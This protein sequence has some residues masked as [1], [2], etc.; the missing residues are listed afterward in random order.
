MSHC[1]EIIAVGTE[2]LL[3]NIVNSDAQTVAQALSELGIN[4]YY[5]T[6]VGDNPERL[7][8]AVEIARSRAD[9]IITTGGLGPTFDDLTKQTLA[10]AFGKKLVLHEEELLKI[11]R[12]FEKIGRK[13]TA[14]NEQ[15]AW[16]PEGCT[17]L[18]NDWGTAPGCAFEADG[19]HVIMLPGPPRECAPMMR[20][21]A[22]P[23]LRALSD[24]TLVSH[25][26]HIFGMGEGAVENRIRH[27]AEAMDNPTLAPYAKEGEVL[28]R[29]T[30]R[31][32]D[33]EHADALTQPVLTMLAEEFSDLIYGVDVPSLADVVVSALRERGLKL[34]TAESCTGGLLSKMVTDLPGASDVFLGGVCAYHNE[35]K[36]RLLGV[37]VEIL[38][39]DGA[40]SR[41]CARAMAKGAAEA[42]GADVGVGITG[43]AGPDGGS[44]EKPVGTVYLSVW[45]DGTYWDKKLSH[46]AYRGGVRN[47]A[48]L[49]ALDLIRR[50][51]A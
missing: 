32:A 10:E 4:V 15:Q 18:K 47:M 16:L 31:A 38:E 35:V 34:A 21:R 33:T 29:V 9:I 23:Y 13:M 24:A 28:L 11:H 44:P 19:V 40:V 50:V 7:K 48:A 39:T 37:P 26:V 6:V 22:M 43:I 41:A 45:K 2:I 51:L 8:S 20:E 1:A 42:I 5:N 36:K 3:G 14:N 25:E 17:V 12:Y 46:Q 30:G 27:I 49:H